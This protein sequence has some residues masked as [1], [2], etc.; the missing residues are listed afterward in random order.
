MVNR[1]EAC[2]VACYAHFTAKLHQLK[3]ALGQFEDLV[4]VIMSTRENI[5]LMARTPL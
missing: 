3:K 5:R 1:F 4:F 2:C